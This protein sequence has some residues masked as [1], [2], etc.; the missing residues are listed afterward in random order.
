MP[1]AGYRSTLGSI[2][3]MLARSPLPAFNGERTLQI[4]AQLR[5]SKKEKSLEPVIN[6]RVGGAGSQFCR[7]L[8]ARSDAYRV[9]ASDE[10]RR[11]RENWPQPSGLRRKS[12][13]TSL[14][15]SPRNSLSLRPPPRLARFALATTPAGKLITGSRIQFQSRDARAN[16]RR[17]FCAGSI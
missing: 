4:G 2:A 9:S 11:N 14:S 16:F 17:I 12:R 5:G 13:D 1:G 3:P 6:F 10:R 15:S 7:V 8:E